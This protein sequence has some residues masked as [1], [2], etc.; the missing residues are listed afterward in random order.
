M[1]LIALGSIFAMRAS[2]FSG[3]AAGPGDAGE[4]QREQAEGSSVKRI[5]FMI[6]GPAIPA[7]RYDAYR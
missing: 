5:V 6:D 4:C 7:R 2:G 1:V 3:S